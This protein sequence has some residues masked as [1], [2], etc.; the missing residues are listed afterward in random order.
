MNRKQ[1]YGKSFLSSRRYHSLG[2]RK[3]MISCDGTRTRILLETTL[4][5]FCTVVSRRV[6]VPQILAVAFFKNYPMSNCQT[7][8]IFINISSSPGSNQSWARRKRLDG[9]YESLWTNFFLL[10][11]CW[12]MTRNNRPSRPFLSLGPK[13]EKIYGW[14]PY[15]VFRNVICVVSLVR[16]F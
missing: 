8:N 10:F 1:Q 13:G 15:P 5:F 4:L 6:R 7:W 9:C 2:L 12:F 11:Y 14:G 3:G 16:R